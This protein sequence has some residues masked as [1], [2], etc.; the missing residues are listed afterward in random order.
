MLIINFFFTIT[1]LI[2]YA[3]MYSRRGHVHGNHIFRHKCWLTYEERNTQSIALNLEPYSNNIWLF[4][5]GEATT[6]NL[7]HFP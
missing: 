1:F 7:T 6:S 5:V 4:D 2:L 3:K